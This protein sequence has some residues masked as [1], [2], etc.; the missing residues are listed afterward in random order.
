MAIVF[1]AVRVLLGVFFMVV[2]ATK[3]TDRI[4]PKLYAEA[5]DEF[6]KFVDVFPLNDVGAKL[7]PMQY[8]IVVGWIEVIGGLLLAF[9]TKA[10]Q[11]ISNIILSII[12]MG[13]IY[14]LLVS[15][16][17]LYKCIPAIVC[18]GLLLLLLYV[19]RRDKEKQKAE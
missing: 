2:G 14:F 3:L 17:P 16:K 18:L 1:V 11:E 5:V 10:L 12:M 13:A 7:E 6:A 19:W 8:Q 4:S 9:G 15:K